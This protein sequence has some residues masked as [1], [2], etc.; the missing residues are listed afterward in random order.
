MTNHHTHHREQIRDLR[1]IEKVELHLRQPAC[2]IHVAHVEKS[3]DLLTQLISAMAEPVGK[4]LTAKGITTSVVVQLQRRP[5]AAQADNARFVAYRTL[6]KDSPV[7]NVAWL[8]N[9]A[10][11]KSTRCVHYAVRTFAALAYPPTT[12]PT[13]LIL[14][15][16]AV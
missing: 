13:S 15:F 6:A 11:W 7:L 14:V 8:L 1:K 16:Q 2:T 9:T 10:T 12:A 3:Y 4:N 5:Q